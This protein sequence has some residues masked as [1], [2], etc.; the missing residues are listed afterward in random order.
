MLAN[1]GRQGKARWPSTYAAGSRPGGVIAADLNGD[2]LTD[3]AVAN[4]GS[5]SITLLFNLGEGK[6]A[7]G[8]TAI[9]AER[10]SSLSFAPPPAAATGAIVCSHTATE[11]LGVLPTADFPR[12]AS[13]ITIPTGARPHVLESRI[14]S[15]SLQ[16]ILRYRG[17][18]R[19]TVALSVFEQIGGG[20]FLERSMRFAQGEKIAAATMERSSGG[21]AYTVGFVT[22]NP[23]RG[24]STL[25][26]ADV[27]SS[28]AVGKITPVLTFSDSAGAVSGVLPATLRQGGRRDYIVVL[29]KPTNALLIAYRQPDGSFRTD[30][31]WIRN[32]SVTGDDDVV[33]ADVDGDG[34]PD[35]T[36]R[37]DASGAILTYYGGALG[38]REP[39][40]IA[41]AKGVRGFAVG[42]VFGRRKMDLVLT[43]EEEGTVSLIPDPFRRTP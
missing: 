7:G 26:V 27:T 19:N 41:S 21:S 10:P 13:F 11:M 33:V 34:R 17:D 29:G 23:G 1:A 30:P 28:F 35:I 43:H 2:G 18:E 39:E 40:R 4:A 42:P 9:V 38:F 6:F 15:A 12:T 36:L 37:D 3:I 22:T 16:I 25:Q 32:V 24:S 8:A 14:D 20:Q 31:E 5:S